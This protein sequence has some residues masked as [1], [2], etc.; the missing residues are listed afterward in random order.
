VVGV[1]LTIAGWT[2]FSFG[3]GLWRIGA[4]R[5]VRLAAAT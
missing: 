4:P 3:L 2:L 5:P 1:L